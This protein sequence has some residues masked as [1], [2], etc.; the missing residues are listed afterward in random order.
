MAKEEQ[1]VALSTDYACAT[2]KTVAPYQIGQIAGFPELQNLCEGLLVLVFFVLEVLSVL[3]K[4]SR[5][6]SRM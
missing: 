1:E 5:T 4:W 6:L 2:L 3:V